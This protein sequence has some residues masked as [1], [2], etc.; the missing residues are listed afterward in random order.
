MLINQ[1]QLF[2]TLSRKAG[3]VVAAMGNTLRELTVLSPPLI[4]GLRLMVTCQ[5]GTKAQNPLGH[6]TSKLLK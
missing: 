2:Y 3:V 1:D 5:V 6:C 4:E